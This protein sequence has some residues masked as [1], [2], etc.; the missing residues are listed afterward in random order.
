MAEIPYSMCKI[1]QRLF[2]ISEIAQYQIGK[3]RPFGIAWYCIVQ[4]NIERGGDKLSLAPRHPD[5]LNASRINIGKFL[6]TS[7]T[8]T[9]CSDQVGIETLSGY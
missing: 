7:Y 8:A 1:V 5:A 2:L 4:H 3:F 6:A 9:V